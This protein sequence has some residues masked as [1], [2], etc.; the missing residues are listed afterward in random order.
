MAP[1]N[2]SFDVARR[3]VLIG[4][5]WTAPAIVIASSSPARATSAGDAVVQITTGSAMTTLLA[6][7]GAA[8]VPVN[9]FD[10]FVQLGDSTDPVARLGSAQVQ[11]SLP[12]VFTDGGGQPAFFWIYGGTSWT[13]MV[14]VTGSDATVILTYTSPNPGGDAPYTPVGGG[15]A[16]RL[17]DTSVVPSP[18]SVVVTAAT[19]TGDPIPAEQPVYSIPNTAA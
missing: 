10:F 5:A 6:Y 18:V 4:A 15:F 2:S 19:D 1:E 16:L 11:Y 7:D 12:N 17:S 13:P 8:S 3:R 9:R 14:S